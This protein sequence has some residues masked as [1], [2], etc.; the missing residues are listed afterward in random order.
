M[1]R[2]IKEGR[3]DPIIT[4]PCGKEFVAKCSIDNIV[5]NYNENTDTDT[6]QFKWVCERC[7][8]I[9]YEN[10][11]ESINLDPIS[12]GNTDTEGDSSN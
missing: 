8:Q 5:G 4:C 2:I 7:G 12:N 11:K 9:F 3:I 6:Y 1:K 10:I